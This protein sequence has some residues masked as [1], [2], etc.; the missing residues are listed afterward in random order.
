ME[1]KPHPPQ[2][3]E[4]RARID[5]IASF[6]AKAGPQAEE[7]LR[8][9]HVGKPQFAYLFGGE[10]SDYYRFA[11]QCE[12]YNMNSGHPAGSRPDNSQSQ[13]EQ[14]PSFDFAAAQMRIDQLRQEIT[15]S[16]VNLK[17]HFDSIPMLRD[18]EFATAI[19]DAETSKTTSYLERVGLNVGGLDD[20]LEQLHS[21]CSKD[22]VSSMKKWI[23]E[24][25]TTDQLREVILMYLLARVRA[26]TSSESFRLH[27]LYLINDWAY[28]CNR[29]KQNGI[30]QVLSRYVPQLY[31]FAA[32][33]VKDPSIV[34]K[35]DKL[36]GTW[37]GSKMFDDS[38]FKTLRNPAIIIQN[39]KTQTQAEHQK[40]GNEINQRLL[41]SFAGYEKQHHEFATHMA[42]QIT[43]IE[44]QIEM[45]RNKAELAHRKNLPSLMPGSRR[46]RFDCGPAAGD[47]GG[48]FNAPS[49]ASAPPTVWNED[50]DVDGSP[51]DMTSA[52]LP[53]EVDEK[54]LIPR[55]PFY[56]LPAGVMMG[57]IK[58]ED[59]T[60]KPIEVS[61]L[62]MPPALPPTPRLLMAM[63]AFYAPPT[64]D[65]QRD[66]QGWEKD[67]LVE[68]YDRKSRLRK[69]LED[70]HC[71]NGK[72]FEDLISN[73]M[74][75]SELEDER[76]EKEA[77]RRKRID[78]YV[79]GSRSLSRG[80]SR[81]RSRSNSRDRER[82]PRRRR[83][84]SSSS[85][86]RSSSRS[87]SPDSRPQFNRRSPS[88]PPARFAA[89]SGPPAPLGSDNKG[90]QLMA[91]MGWSGKGLGA[92]EHGMQDPV[93]GGEVRAGDEKFK[94]LG[95]KEASDEF[96]EYRKRTASQFSE[97]WLNRMV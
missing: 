83:R 49:A 32:D 75:A 46:S 20:L 38:V 36:I 87:L 9:D 33:N 61:K 54:S 13:P 31:A 63:E 67:G 64:S 30:T 37:E 69:V 23:F 15:S 70:T 97:R 92:K 21:K 28:Y 48:F 76:E 17:A 50:D 45:E 8:A 78:R 29:K 82:S 35:L 57:Q 51:M 59:L 91:K 80:R 18:A 47:Y 62:R 1:R 94:G 89:P 19:A 39:Y 43:A 58:I 86:R 93:S 52:P 24:H 5:K 71:I 16:E 81:S 44:A 26:S 55:G 34:Q 25:C 2:D 68:F 56:E 11:L 27:V 88:P 12:I 73:R 40:L 95:F 74:S 7:R 41:N 14:P 3:P 6:V 10:H 53:P 85:S 90:A 77:E 22:V 72:T 84:S 66:S 65:R 60:Y 42:N 79:R 96:T 4:V